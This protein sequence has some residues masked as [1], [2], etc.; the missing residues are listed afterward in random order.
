MSIQ[1]DKTKLGL[2]LSGQPL[3]IESANI[4]ITQPK[5]KDIVLFGEN[6]FLSAVQMLAK[7]EYFTDM[8][9]KGNLD[10]EIIS[11]FQLL[12]MMINQDETVKTLILN[13]FTLIFPD[14]L[15]SVEENSIDF[16]IEQEEGTAKIVGRIHPFNFK[17]F[18]I[19][20]ND[21][22]LPHVDN[23]REP[24]YNPANDAAQKIADKI[25]AGR[26]K[27]HAMQAESDGP[28][29]IFCDQCSTLAVG[30]Q[31][32]INIFFNYTPFQLYDVYKRYFEKVKS[33]FYMR[34][35]T[36][37]LMDTSKMEE[38]LEWHRSLY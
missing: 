23:E 10:L 24:D 4:F 13:L 5:I 16:S 38:P 34:V 3:P 30:L 29:S 32:D 31:M 18:Q 1:G 14:Y 25:K 22:F 33:D 35:S 17:D 11:D 12:M 37:P 19:V 36:M 20:L 15:V 2:I 26:E 21:A 9:K 28:R 6:D 27:V 7:M 8:V